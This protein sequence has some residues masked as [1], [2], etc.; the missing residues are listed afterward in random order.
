LCLYSTQGD[1]YE[2][3]YSIFVNAYLISLFFF[4]FF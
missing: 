3:Q 2:H 1:I 4:R